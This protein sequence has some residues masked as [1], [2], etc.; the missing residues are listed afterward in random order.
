MLN[1]NVTSLNESFSQALQDSDFRKS[2]FFPASPPMMGDNQF[3]EFVTKV[4]QAYQDY[5]HSM[6]F[7][8]SD[9]MEHILYFASEN[10]LNKLAPCRQVNKKWKHISDRLLNR[11]WNLIEQKTILPIAIGDINK[12]NKDRCSI[13]KFGALSKHI[14]PRSVGCTNLK[15]TPIN[16]ENI[17]KITYDNALQIVWR[18]ELLDKLAELNVQD[19]PGRYASADAI[20]MFLE[21]CDAL[22]Q[23]TKLNLRDKNLSVIPREFN[24]LT[25]LTTLD[26]SK[27]RIET[28]QN[29]SNLPLLTALV[30]SDNRIE[31][32]ENLSNLTKLTTLTLTN[33]K[34]ETI[35]NLINLPVLNTLYLSHNGIKTIENLSNLTKLTT[36]FLSH[37]RIETIENLSD[38]KLLNHLDLSDNRIKTIENLGNLPMLN[39]LY[40]SN[41]RIETIESL[42]S[43]LLPELKELDLSNNRIERIQNLDNLQLLTKLYLDG[44]ILM[45]IPDE[46]VQ[47][48][49]NNPEIKLFNEQ[50]NYKCDFQLA[51]LYQAIMIPMSEN[52]L[53]EM[54][55]LLEQKDKQLILQL[56]EKKNQNIEQMKAFEDL[57]CFQSAVQKTILNKFDSLSMEKQEEVYRTIYELAG[58]PIITDNPLNWAKA[59]AKKHIPRLAEALVPI[60]NNDNSDQERV[61]AIE[62]K[63]KLPIGCSLYV[64]GSGN[65]LSWN[66]GIELKNNGNVWVFKS[67]KPLEKGECKFLL[68][69]DIKYWEKG[70]NR[71]I[72]AGKLLNS[73]P[74]NF[75][76]L[77]KDYKNIEV[78]IKF[79]FDEKKYRLAIC[80]C[81]IDGVG[82][83]DSKNPIY[84]SKE[85]GIWRTQ[86]QKKEGSDSILFKYVLVEKGKKPLW[87]TTPNRKPSDTHQPIF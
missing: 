46:I 2:D 14:C 9:T 51:K 36:L 21:N 40:L 66:K 32:I 61:F 29:L 24:L 70:N 57:G 4:Y 39:T 23:V 60:S 38:L 45:L 69:D 22:G 84:L 50:K 41:N 31:T 44:N 64:R 49:A 16:P 26:L 17:E 62:C 27:N 75:D 12:I 81:G 18:E 86:I 25:G 15:S 30:L 59:N 63:Q 80:G 72:V 10:K 73:A 35:Q 53:I 33:N 8:R 6:L 71:Q 85:N 82:D 5:K 42:R 83:W 19:L 47:K 11:K 67:S 65:G 34:I 37:N 28:I 55:S 87:E 68:N 79:N 48:F 3:K 52:K 76:N 74:A 1:L 7:G 56:M 13:I 78:S 54:F 77:P 58:S 43:D 20:R